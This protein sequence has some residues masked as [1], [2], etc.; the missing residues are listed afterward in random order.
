MCSIQKL[1]SLQKTCSTCHKN[2]EC[3]PLSVFIE[4][5]LWILK[6]LFS[7]VTNVIRVSKVTSS[8][9]WMSLSLSFYWSDH[10]SS[11]LWVHFFRIALHVDRPMDNVTYRAVLGQLKIFSVC[12]PW[13]EFSLTKDSSQ[14][15]RYAQFM[16]KFKNDEMWSKSYQHSDPTNVMSV[17]I[18]EVKVLKALL[19]TT[20]LP[21]WASK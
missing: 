11:S 15:S 6:L 21:R 2:C 14:R 9:F 17:L 3:F 4:G 8:L 13:T 1:V 19:A 7:I 5:S 18:G 16:T 12:R 20:H 10:V